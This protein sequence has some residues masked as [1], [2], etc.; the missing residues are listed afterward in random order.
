ME[1]HKPVNL[2]RATEGPLKPNGPTCEATSS[3]TVCDVCSGSAHVA[4]DIQPRYFDDD[5]DNN[6]D[7][8]ASPPLAQQGINT[9]ARL[10]GFDDLVKQ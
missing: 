6:D 5:D 2:T 7:D 1:M 3:F 9:H 4:R 8:G 10:V